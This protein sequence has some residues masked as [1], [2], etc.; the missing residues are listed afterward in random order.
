MTNLETTKKMLA[1][2]G[3][4]DKELEEVRDMCDLLAEIVVESLIEKHK[5]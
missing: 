4:T 1:G 5:K 2:L 3:L